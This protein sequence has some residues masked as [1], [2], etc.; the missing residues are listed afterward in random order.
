MNVESFRDQILLPGLAVVE[1]VCDIPVSVEAARF[2]LT[3]MQ[4]ESRLQHRA[5][6]GSSAG[7]PGPA[8]GWGQ[9]ERGGGVKGVMTHPNSAARAKALCEYLGVNWID[10]DIW[11]CLEG[12]DTLAV[13]FSRLLLWTDSHKIPTTEQAAWDCYAKRLWRP[14]KPHP[15][16]WPAYW[17]ISGDVIK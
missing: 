5:Q 13:G 10:W 12:H 1:K 17:R 6:I 9:F 8:R 2:L 3:V 11:R 15:Q 14:G 7:K 16:T 4:Q